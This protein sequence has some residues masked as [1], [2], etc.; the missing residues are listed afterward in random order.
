MVSKTFILVVCVG[1]LTGFSDAFWRM[2]C[3]IIQTGRIDPV[4]SPGKISGH[5]HK[6]AG[7]SNIGLDSTYNTLQQSN[8]T[9]CEIQKDKSA[10]WTPQL[11]YHLSNG[12]FEEVPNQGMTVYYLGRGNNAANIKPFPE[13]FRMLSGN[14]AARS[15]NTQNLTYQNVRP[16]ADRVSFACLQA[17]PSAETPGMNE[18]NCINGLRAQVHFQSCWDGVN[19]YK[20]DNSH[21]AYMSMMDNGVCPPEYPVQFIH[22]FYEV[23]YSVNNVNLDGGNFAFSQ[24][25]TTGYGFHGDFLNGWDMDVQTQAMEQCANTAD[26]VVKDCAPLAASDIDD[27]SDVCATQA[28]LVQEQTGPMISKLPGCIT[29]TSGPEDASMADMVC[30]AGTPEPAVASGFVAVG[31]SSAMAQAADATALATSNASPR[32]RGVGWYGNI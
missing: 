7:A 16:I 19:L 23:L 3:G 2:S 26:G 24:G 1:S 13:G 14:A 4:V 6:I 20:E 17:N 28:P 22:L 8:C 11:Y 5:V 25:D 31:S 10:Y 30:A 12:S 21:V 18:T 15:Y 32:R 9:S 27:F 29:I